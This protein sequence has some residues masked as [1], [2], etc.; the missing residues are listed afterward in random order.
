MEDYRRYEVKWRD[1]KQ[2][3]NQNG[4]RIEYGFLEILL[5]SS[6]SE[7]LIQK[8]YEANVL[9]R[10]RYEQVLSDICAG[11]KASKLIENHK[12]NVERPL[13]RCHRIRNGIVHAG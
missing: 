12:E 6:N 4:K 7:A 10:Y 9:F 8:S 3:S 11:R 13:H 5:S 1:D 2:E